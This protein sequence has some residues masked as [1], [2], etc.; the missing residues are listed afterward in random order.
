MKEKTSNTGEQP[1]ILIAIPAY[2]GMI[3]FKTS[4]ALRV[5]DWELTKLGIP[6]TFRYLGNESLI[7]RARNWFANLALIGKEENGKPFT[8]LLF[9]DADI[10]FSPAN[11]WKCSRQICPSLPCRIPRRALIGRTSQLLQKL[12]FLRT[13]C[14]TTRAPLFLISMANLT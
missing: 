7:T 2:G 9:V 14:L 4:E 5:L 12:V 6:H 11:V 1:N 13:S 8:H 3:H 10:I